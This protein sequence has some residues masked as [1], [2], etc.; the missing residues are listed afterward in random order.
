MEG[1]MLSGQKSPFQLLMEDVKRRA[2]EDAA[3]KIDALAGND[4][5]TQAW[6]VAARVVREMKP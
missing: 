6:K 5:Y 4:A 3:K 2:L 1:E